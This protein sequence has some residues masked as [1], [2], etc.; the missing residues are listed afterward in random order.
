MAGWSN[1]GPTRNSG[2]AADLHPLDRVHLAWRLFRD[3]RVSPRLKKLVPAFVALYV[4][5]PI[6]LIP[7]FLIGL[8]QV[9]DIGVIGLAMA[10][11]TLALRFAPRELIA[12]HLAAMGLWRTESAART[13]PSGN[14]GPTVEAHH[15]VRP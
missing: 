3:P 11:L 15:R 8:G 14:V 10:A 5:S 13:P 12:E 1:T 6:D 7:D 4:L 9:D 2:A